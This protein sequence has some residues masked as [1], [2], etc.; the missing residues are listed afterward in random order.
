LKNIINQLK[1][2]KLYEKYKSDIKGIKHGFIAILFSASFV[3]SLG[4]VHSYQNL[5]ESF[6]LYLFS[7]LAYFVAF[8]YKSLSLKFITISYQKK[9]QK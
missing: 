8:L 4:F 1:E 9:L 2:K 5:P 3:L 7:I 6:N